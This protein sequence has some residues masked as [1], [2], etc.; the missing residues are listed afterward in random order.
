L[1]AT[2]TQTQLGLGFP[3]LNLRRLGAD[4]GGD[5]VCAERGSGRLRRASRESRH[6]ACAGRLQRCRALRRGEGFGS[7]LSRRAESGQA[8]WVGPAERG[9]GAGGR[10][11]RR[12]LRSAGSPASPAP[13]DCAAGAAAARGPAAGGF[14]EPQLVC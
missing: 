2:L 12:G 11:R 6:C 4:T 10:R 8:A 9:R 3:S 1:P 7:A 13:G 5:P 14:Q